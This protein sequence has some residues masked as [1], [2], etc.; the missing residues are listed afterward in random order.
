[1]AAKVP[2][3]VREQRSRSLISLSEIKHREF[4]ISNQNSVCSVLFEHARNA[5]MITGFT[6]NYIRVEHPWDSSLA[7]KIKRV[8]LRGISLYDRMTAELTD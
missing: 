5:G 4:C 1:M 3:P 2:Y 7:G 6:E 8:K